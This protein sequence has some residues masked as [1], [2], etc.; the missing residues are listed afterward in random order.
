[1]DKFSLAMVEHKWFIK[2]TLTHPS[3][4]F[5]SFTFSW[6]SHVGVEQGVM[7]QQVKLHIL[8]NYGIKDT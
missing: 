3:H 7:L 4:F 8:D 6:G 2:F 5:T 1:M